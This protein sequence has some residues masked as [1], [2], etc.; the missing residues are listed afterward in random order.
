L[1]KP[2][3]P[4]L[5]QDDT[6]ARIAAFLPDA[7]ARAL[8]SYQEFARVPPG[9]GQKEFTAHHAACKA[10]AS[11]IELLIKL[12]QRAGLPD[13]RAADHNNQILL[14]AML[15]E[16]QGELSRHRSLYA[17]EEENI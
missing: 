14:A 5:L 15:Q 2:V 16:A 11:H 3:S 10:A 4:E 1:D 7:I 12:A 9:G 17:E 6:R 13:A 8:T